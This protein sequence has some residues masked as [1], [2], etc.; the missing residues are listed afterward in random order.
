MG[1]DELANHEETIRY[2]LTSEQEKIKLDSILKSIETLYSLITYPDK[3]SVVNSD[4]N[5]LSNSDKNC[6]LLD[7]N[8][9]L[10]NAYIRDL[11]SKQQEINRNL[12]NNK[13]SNE[14]N[15]R[16]LFEEFL[17]DL[18]GYIKLNRSCKVGKD[19]N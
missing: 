14:A 12:I 2:M 10:V 3:Y 6:R 7:L 17:V 4:N 18:F 8:P 19:D 11:V 15:Q 1:D 5:Y 16:T 9:M 13:I